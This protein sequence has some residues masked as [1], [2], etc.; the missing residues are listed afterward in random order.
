MYERVPLNAPIE[1]PKTRKKISQKN[2]IKIEFLLWACCFSCFLIWFLFIILLVLLDRWLNQLLLFRALLRSSSVKT[3]KLKNFLFPSCAKQNRKMAIC[4]RCTTPAHWPTAKNST[5]G[6]RTLFI[7]FFNISF[8]RRA[9]MC[10]LKRWLNAHHV[11]SSWKWNRSLCKMKIE[12]VKWNVKVTDT[13]TSEHSRK[14]DRRIKPNFTQ[15]VCWN[16][17]QPQRSTSLN[18][19]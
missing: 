2:P 16:N 10:A 1:N 13:R 17:E 6:K 8:Y 12:T 19:K 5:R 15:F 14:T 9:C 18:Y 3:W 11:S 4:W 7:Y